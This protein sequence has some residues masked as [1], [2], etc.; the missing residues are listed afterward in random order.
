MR[1]IKF[2]KNLPLYSV[3]QGIDDM[4]DPEHSVIG[5]VDTIFVRL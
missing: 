4:G 3:Q 1:S 5:N 2:L